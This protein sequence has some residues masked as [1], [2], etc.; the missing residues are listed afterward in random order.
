M[1]YI[2]LT[3]IAIGV[4][5]ISNEG[6]GILRFCGFS[7][8]VIGALVLGVVVITGGAWVVSQ[9]WKPIIEGAVLLA[10]LLSV[11]IFIFVIV[12]NYINKLLQTKERQRVFW[13]LFSVCL[14]ALFIYRLYMNYY[15]P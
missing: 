3:I 8:L 2:L 5:L 1:L 10:S 13:V 11:W 9:V 14:V 6:K 4:L 15:H 7:L 12:P